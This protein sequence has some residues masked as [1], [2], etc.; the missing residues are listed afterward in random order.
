MEAISKGAGTGAGIGFWVGGS[1]EGCGSDSEGDVV[2]GGDDRGFEV[3][4]ADLAV[5]VG[6][7]DVEGQAEV[8]RVAAVGG[9]GDLKLKKLI[10]GASRLH[11][12]SITALF[13]EF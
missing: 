5:T 4:E 8:R 2:G 6:V 7:E 11:D 12:G 9:E 1:I 13:L 3:A 10:I